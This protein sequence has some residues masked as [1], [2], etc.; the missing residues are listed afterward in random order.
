[1]FSAVTMYAPGRT[2]TNSY[3]PSAFDERV[4]DTPVAVLVSGTFA[5]GTT[6]PD[7]SRTVPTTEAVSNCA[8]AG[9]AHSNRNTNSEHTRCRAGFGMRSMLSTADDSRVKRA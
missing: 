6:A 3:N 8:N 2:V 9:T 7:A 5:S 1:A 4:A